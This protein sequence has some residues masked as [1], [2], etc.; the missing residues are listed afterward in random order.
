M[1]QSRRLELQPVAVLRALAASF[2]RLNQAKSW[3]RQTTSSPSMSHPNPSWLECAWASILVIAVVAWAWI[4]GADC[5]YDR[6][7]TGASG[8]RGAGP[9]EDSRRV[10]QLRLAM[11][12][13]GHHAPGFSVSTLRRIIADVHGVPDFLDQPEILQVM[14]DPDHPA[15]FLDR[16]PHP[17]FHAP[18]PTGAA[19]CSGLMATSAQASARGRICMAD[20]SAA[21]LGCPFVGAVSIGCHS[22]ITCLF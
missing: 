3:M 9:V 18:A 10:G 8:D 1:E 6:Y 13:P 20:R 21:G 5:D 7:T 12:Q 4:T 11:M 16:P 22:D 14:Q 19:R 15:R 2:L 17:T